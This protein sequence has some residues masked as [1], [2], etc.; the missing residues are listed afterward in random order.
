MSQQSSFSATELHSQQV[1][2]G[3]SVKFQDS[4]D[5]C[6]RAAAANALHICGATKIAG[7]FWEDEKD[8]DKR[9]RELHGYNCAVRDNND[10]V[11]VMEDGLLLW[12]KINRLRQ[13]SQG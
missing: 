7:K 1:E 5:E 12:K 9:F 8:R 11:K 2:N 4:G 10:I 13:S 6:V 3:I